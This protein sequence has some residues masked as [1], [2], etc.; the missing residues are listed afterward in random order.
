[1]VDTKNNLSQNPAR[2]DTGQKE[3]ERL[4]AIIKKQAQKIR[5]LQAQ[6]AQQTAE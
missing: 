4:I 3:K 1:M 5:E 2:R 6:E